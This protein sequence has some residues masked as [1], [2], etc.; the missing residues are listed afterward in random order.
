M[1]GFAQMKPIVA[2]IPCYIPDQAEGSPL[3][4]YVLNAVAEVVCVAL[5]IAAA[6]DGNLLAAE[7]GLLDGVQIIIPSCARSVPRSAIKGKFILRKLERKAFFTFRYARNSKFVHPAST[8]PCP[9]TSTNNNR[10]PLVLN[11]RLILKTGLPE[12]Q[13]LKSAPKITFKRAE[14]K[15]NCGSDPLT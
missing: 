7:V 14:T 8:K 2:Y 1:Q 10:F 12:F 3:Q 11:P 13:I 9:K 5:G 4:R 15:V 6:E